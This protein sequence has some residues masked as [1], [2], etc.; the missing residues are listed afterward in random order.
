MP[1]GTVALGATRQPIP[2]SAPAPGPGQGRWAKLTH[3]APSGTVHRFTSGAPIAAAASDCANFMNHGNWS[4][5]DVVTVSGHSEALLYAF[6]ADNN[7]PPDS[8]Q[9]APA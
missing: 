6:I 3:A 7:G 1:S 5:R 8:Q 9:A 2:R 4:I